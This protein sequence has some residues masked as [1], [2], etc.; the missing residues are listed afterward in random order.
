MLKNLPPNLYHYNQLRNIHEKI[1]EYY[2]SQNKNGEKTHVGFVYL[3]NKIKNIKNTK[4]IGMQ[5]IDI[6]EN[7]K[8]LKITLNLI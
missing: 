4:E 2:L 5:R 7:I 6:K 8:L 3:N 1:N